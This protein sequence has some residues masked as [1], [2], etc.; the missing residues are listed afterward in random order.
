MIE[1]KKIEG[2]GTSNE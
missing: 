1:R 2:M